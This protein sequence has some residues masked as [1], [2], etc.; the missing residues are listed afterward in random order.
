M[1]EPEK[2]CVRCLEYWPADTEF[3]YRHARKADGLENTCKACL[4]ESPSVKAR[5]AN[6]QVS[7][8]YSP[9]ESLFSN[10]ARSRASG[11]A[12]LSP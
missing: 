10:E 9:W 4:S 3:F 7:R 11:A 1:T 6:R 8:M 2:L 5:Q 12:G